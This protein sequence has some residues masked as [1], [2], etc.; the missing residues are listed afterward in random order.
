[1]LSISC[2]RAL[3]AAKARK[4]RKKTPTLNRREERSRSRMV[5]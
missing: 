4:E 2:R 5:L 3:I 1:M